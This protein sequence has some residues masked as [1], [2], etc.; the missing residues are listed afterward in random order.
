MPIKENLNFNF[1]K[2]LESLVYELH[3]HIKDIPNPVVIPCIGFKPIIDTITV[4]QNLC[5]T[6]A[7]FVNDVGQ[8]LMESDLSNTPNCTQ[9]TI[10]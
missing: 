8:P 3:V 7:V 4:P 1:T 5:I 2:H 6:H 10:N 9:I